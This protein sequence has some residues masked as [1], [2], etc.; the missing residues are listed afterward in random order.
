MRETPLRGR[1]PGEVL[2]DEGRR[3]LAALP[4]GARRVALAV[5]GAVLELEAFAAVC[6]VDRARR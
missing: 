6:S 2:R 5:A 1:S 4:A 3:L